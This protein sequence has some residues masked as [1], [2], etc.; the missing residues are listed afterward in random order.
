MSETMNPFP[1]WWREGQVLV[2]I[3]PVG[4]ERRMSDLEMELVGVMPALGLTSWLHRR[5]GWR[6]WEVITSTEDAIIDR[7]RFWTARGA[8]R[9]NREVFGVMD[10]MAQRVAER[11]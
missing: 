9:V 1:M 4:G 6:K 8:R 11:E 10:L 5:G 3:G 7:S 2:P